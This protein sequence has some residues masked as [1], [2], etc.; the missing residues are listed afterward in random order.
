MIHGSGRSPEGATHS[1]ILAWRTPWTEE[2]GRLQSIGSQ[3]VRH[4]GSDLAAAAGAIEGFPGGTS[5]KEPACKCRRYKRYRFD[6]WVG[7]IP[8]R[9]AWLST[10]VFLPGEPLG[11]KNRQG[12]GGGCYSPRGWKEWDTTEQ[13]T[14]S[15]FQDELLTNKYFIKK[16]DLVKKILP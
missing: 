2:P 8:W 1:S 6:P 13:L 12:G 3:K 15:H 4:D 5:D 9:R 10:P 7:K 16:G 14:L 11:Q